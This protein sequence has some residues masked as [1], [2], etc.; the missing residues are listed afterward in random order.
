MDI[1]GAEIGALR[2]SGWLERVDTLMVELHDRFRPGCSEALDAAARGRGFVETRSGEYVVLSRP[3]A[4]R[5]SP[6]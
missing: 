1:E 6:S 5:Q 2:D 4:G 3:S